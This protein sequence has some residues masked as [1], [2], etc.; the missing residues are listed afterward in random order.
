MYGHFFCFS[1]LIGNITISGNC[2]V[3]NYK[4]YMH[5][6]FCFCNLTKFWYK[7]CVPTYWSC[8]RKCIGTCSK[9]YNQKVN[10]LTDDCLHADNKKIWQYGSNI[11]IDT[12][13]YL[14]WMTVNS[15][16]PVVHTSEKSYGSKRQKN[17]C[18]YRIL[19]TVHGCH[20]C[21]HSE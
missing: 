9:I 21:G 16:I 7:C 11:Y 14:C 10:Y 19:E 5:E 15:I 20:A 4:S 17:C 1:Q 2:R 12:H 8:I 3:R 18:T 6:H 13:K